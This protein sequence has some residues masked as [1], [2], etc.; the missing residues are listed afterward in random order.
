MSRVA[1][2]REVLRWARRRAG[3]TVD[4]LARKFPKVE[5]WEREEVKPTLR[6]LEAFAKA[7]LT[8]I[9]YFFLPEPPEDR[10]PIPDFRTVRDEPIR[11]PS[12]NLLE[13]VQVMQ[14]RQAW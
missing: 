5:Q 12:P 11:R 7:T 3:L 10:L 13:T 6:Q 1:V 9:G 4:S 14:R 8:P 2:K